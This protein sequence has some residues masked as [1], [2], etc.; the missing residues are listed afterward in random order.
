MSFPQS[1]LLLADDASAGGAV[2][3]SVKPVVP[4]GP[5]AWLVL[6]IF[7]CVVIVPFL[8]GNVLAK[9]LK[10]K[11]LSLKLGITLF[12]LTLA[13]SPFIG[14][15]VDNRSLADCF[16]LGID[17]EG[18]TNMVFQVD[19]ERA[20]AL[21]KVQA[22]E[23]IDSQLMGRM[24]GAIRRRLNV[25]GVE[26]IV[27]RQVGDDRIEVIV[28]GRDDQEHVDQ[29][30]NK[31]VDLG[32]LEISR[33][34]NTVED[35]RVCASGQQAALAGEKD[36]REGN[37]L[38]AQWR[39]VG[40][41]E[42]GQPKVIG[43]HDGCQ[44]LDFE[45]RGKPQWPHFLVI[46]ETDPAREITGRLLTR[47]F[48]TMD[49]QGLPAVGFQ[50][51]LEG[52]FLFQQLTA[53]H[54]PK[55]ASNHRS[56]LAIVLS[57]EVHSAPSI[58]TMISGGTGIIHGQFTPAEVR[59][60]TEVLNA[61]A[62]EIP[63]VR[64]P[65]SRY[66]ISP[67]LG[68]D[69][70]SKGVNAIFW[71]AI[72]VV[73]F[74]LV[75]YLFAGVVACICL[76]C[77]ILLIMGVMAL[78]DATFT[79]PGLAGLVLTIG[80]AVDANVLIF[81]RMREEM[82]KGSSIRM[83][84]Q[85]GFGKAL[86]SIVDSNVT[87]MITGIVLYVIGTDQVKGFAVTLCIG[88]VMTMFTAIYIGRLIFDICERNHW[89]KSLHMLGPKKA[90]N[91]RFF[92]VTWQAVTIS[93]VII[94][95]GMV[96]MFVRGE[97]NF[98]ID[99]R[100]GSMVTF[101]FS[102]DP[103][104]FEEV[105]SAIKKQFEVGA[106][107]EELKS[108]DLKA[109]RLRTTLDTRDVVSE[110]ITAA[111]EDT[112]FT[113]LRQNVEF[114]SELTPIPEVDGTEDSYAGGHERMVSVEV[115]TAAETL[116]GAIVEVLGEFQLASAEEATTNESVAPAGSPKY[117]DP[118]SLI[119]VVARDESVTGEHKSFQVRLAPEVSAEDAALLFT[120]LEAELEAEPIYE[121][122]TQFK[123]SVAQD[124]MV[125]AILAILISFV[126]IVAYLWFRFHGYTFGIAAVVALLHD[127]LMVLG[128]M[129]LCSL[130][131]GN[132]ISKML[133]LEDFKINLPIVAAI[134]TL[135]GYSLNDTIVTFDRIREIRG[136][137]PKLTIE[138]VDASVNQ[139][140]SRTILTAL[141]VF[142]VVVILY[143]WG[144]EGIHGFAFSLVI[145]VI[146]GS[147]SSIYMAAPVLLWLINRDYNK[148]VA[149][150]NERRTGTAS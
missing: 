78:I 49:D 37:V 137:S 20:I 97:E 82:A 40:A 105:D 73:V 113:L 45:Y 67:T 111:F 107:I 94:A 57:G 11:D 104:T 55:E 12:C 60:L 41:D 44:L 10:V 18:G 145:G 66:Q 96:A 143:I 69:V 2:L 63:L 23:T 144:G 99:F 85:N 87:T 98:D 148:S 39:P 16:R 25:S 54:Q 35:E 128:V 117:T 116:Q 47:A 149:A 53:L 119:E 136:R 147:Y 24:V 142:I 150:A 83:A 74:M 140:L 114:V 58:E 5:S 84:I 13:I 88:I 115:S 103:P 6:L 62:L 43:A 95:A 51:N 29:I 3:E 139:T 108:G 30:I 17:L 46:V 33:L 65:I 38:I 4:T 121:E 28:P 101:S 14:A 125:S 56:R 34:A 109:F 86:S 120:T 48:E 102:G 50:F 110:K 146:A 70:R 118:V 91:F 32:S 129:A 75:Y 132:S 9:L 106:T 112:P 134:L 130:I 76:A 59:E 8:L 22:G 81:E 90:F 79:L 26:E 71:S 27:V 131:S 135:M 52:G 141:T 89:I 31:I 92:A 61:G 138:M 133:L 19:M 68:A 64:E 126:A 1:W 123:S 7:L 36:V 80:M 72:A 15:L 93:V 21:E 100:G 77:N 122:T 124:V 127:V 42:D